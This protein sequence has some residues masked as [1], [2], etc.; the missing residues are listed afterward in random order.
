MTHYFCYYSFSEPLPDS[1]IFNH[2]GGLQIAS[3]G[4][5]Q[6]DMMAPNY[7]QQ[8]N[9]L[10]DTYIPVDSYRNQL[11]QQQ[12]QQQQWPSRM[13]GWP[14]QKQ[15]ASDLGGQQGLSDNMIAVNTN[16]WPEM[17]TGKIAAKEEP[18]AQE[19]T[20]GDDKT[21]DYYEDEDEVKP[22]E[23]P[24]KKQRKHKKQ[25]P[26][27]GKKTDDSNPH[28]EQLKLVKNEL[29]MEFPDHDG[30]AQ[31]PGGAML[32]LTLGMIIAAALAILI[33]CRMRVVGRRIRRH[34]KGYATDAD[35][36]VN[37]MYL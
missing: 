37:G 35:F 6:Y 11:L 16:K 13:D 21:G 2:K 10:R 30:L 9:N 18:A 25:K 4:G 20:G 28:H 29:S 15:M 17:E 14:Q 7:N 33:G 31:R 22:T 23:P 8:T 34:G 27:D 26:K 1:H 19:K 24:K 36:L 5:Q 32:S 3:N 12:Q